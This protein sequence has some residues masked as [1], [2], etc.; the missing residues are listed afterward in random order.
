MNLPRGTLFRCRCRRLLRLAGAVTGVIACVLVLSGCG[1]K[2]TVN[3]AVPQQIL[4]A[5]VA[6][7]DE[8]LS[9]MDRYMK[10]MSLSCS[11]MKVTA[12]LGN[13]D[14]GKV[15]EYRSAP[16]YI[17]LQRPDRIRLVVQNPVTRTSLLDI[18]SIGDDFS[19]YYVRNRQFLIGKNSARDL[20][21]PG[22]KQ[23]AQF[24]LR[25]I[26]LYEAILPQAISTDGADISVSVKEHQ[27]AQAKYYVLSVV[28]RMTLP[29]D[30]AV[31]DI[32]I[33]RSTL[34][35]ARQV[36]YEDDGRV[37]S[38]IFYLKM[39]AGTLPLPLSLRIERPLD[40]YSMDME[41]S[42][43]KLDPSLPANAFTLTPPEGVQVIQLKEKQ[44]SDTF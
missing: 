17:L 7:R 33:E 19:A 5:K 39:S 38:R 24:G 18:S 44:R 42:S 36:I 34:A 35:P 15:E 16:G 40:S 25:P 11:S 3:V 21:I 30:Q 20:E 41:F 23:G 43:W 4:N 12:T 29:W 27:D 10:V 13:A 9:I 32:W 1:V 37:A 8:L 31:R 22:E 26:H 2:R 6:S 28:K 14:T